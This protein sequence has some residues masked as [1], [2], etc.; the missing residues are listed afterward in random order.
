MEIKF[1]K[2]NYL[3]NKAKILQT[4]YTLSFKSKYFSNEDRNKEL[5][6]K[7]SYLQNKLSELENLK[8][9]VDKNYKNISDKVKK[10]ENDS[11]VIKERILTKLGDKHD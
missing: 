11:L 8:S 4:L 5:Q 1:V 3:Q 2:K 9:S 10:I 6:E 7:I